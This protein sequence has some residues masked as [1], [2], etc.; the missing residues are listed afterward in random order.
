VPART[1]H[2]RN[3]DSTSKWIRLA[4]AVAAVDSMTGA[5]IRYSW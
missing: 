2:H 1:F 5:T 3:A 4:W